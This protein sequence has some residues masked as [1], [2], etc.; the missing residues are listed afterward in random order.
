MLQ[1]NFATSIEMN[2]YWFASVPSKLKNH[3]CR[4]YTILGQI[5][6]LYLPVILVVSFT[7]GFSYLVMSFSDDSRTR[8]S[9]IIVFAFLAALLVLQIIVLVIYHGKRPAKPRSEEPHSEQ[10]L[11]GNNRSQEGVDS[12]V[13]SMGRRLAVAQDPAGIGRYP[14]GLRHN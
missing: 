3:R 7:T 2:R 4:T 5:A 11:P 8:R 12:G 13:D 14:E 1:T 9:A 6:S 10:L